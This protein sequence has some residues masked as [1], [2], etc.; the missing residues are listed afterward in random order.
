MSNLLSLPEHIIVEIFT[1]ITIT[2]LLL[3]VA[4]TCKYLNDIINEN[5]KLWRDIDLDFPLVA[6]LDTLKRILNHSFGFKSFLIPY[7][8]LTCTVYEIDFLLTRTLPNSKSLFWLDISR[9]RLST[10]CFL[11]LMPHLQILNIS[12]CTNLVDSDFQVLEQCKSLDQ[13]YMSYNNVE[14]ETVV[15]VCSELKL[16]VLDLSGVRMKVSQCDKILKPVMLH[17][18][19]SL[20]EEESEIDIENLRSK[21]RDCSI[22]IVHP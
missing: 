9:C 13:L 4:P 17:F 22:R 14:P 3:Y 2:D 11:N 6:N 15:R 21:W 8:E 20:A 1:N 5:S 19:V 12:E 16:T 7:A 18:Q 10:L